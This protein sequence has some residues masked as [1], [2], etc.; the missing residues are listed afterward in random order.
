MANTRSRPVISK[1]FVMLRS[2]QTIESVPLFSRSRLTPLTRTPSV[3]ESMKVVLVK[4][5]TTSSAPLAINSSICDFSSG[6]VYRSTSPV[7]AITCL[8]LPTCS[9]SMLKSTCVLPEADGAESLT[10]RH[11]GRVRGLADCLDLLFDERGGRVVRRKLDELLVRGDGRFRVAGRL[12]GLPEIELRVR[13][14]R[15]QTDDSPVDEKRLVI[16]V[17]LLLIERAQLRVRAFSEALEDHVLP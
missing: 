5:T 2:S 12:G 10:A 15:V 13:V 14:F 1:I 6:A 8:A 17:L 9:V 4:S 7:R 16:V 3:V 11:G